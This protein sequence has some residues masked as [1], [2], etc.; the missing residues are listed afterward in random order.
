MIDTIVWDLDGT[1]L[2]TLEDL[3][4]S[5]NYALQ[6]NGY[7]AK[8]MKDI[9]RYLGNGIRNLVQQSMPETITEGE[10]DKTFNTFKNYY[11]NHCC[12]KTRPYEGII[13]VMAELK[14]EGYKMAIVSNKAHKAVLDL[15][16]NFFS[17]FISVAI[18]ESEGIKRKP[19]PDMVNIALERLGSTREN[20]V[21][22]G[23]SEVD[24]QTAFNSGMP[25]ISVLWGFRD[26]DFLVKQ[27]ATL[28]VREP[29]EIKPL[30][31]Q[32]IPANA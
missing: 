29:N 12:I 25:C 15:N 1:I 14:R 23:D 31:S 5:V 3:S 16:N 30:L 28:F 27:G 10:L 17:S 18:G 22:I 21:Y 20:A 24:L 11:F 32:L 9:R 13:Q 19:A 4:D 26:E 2:N 7:P 8:E 6:L